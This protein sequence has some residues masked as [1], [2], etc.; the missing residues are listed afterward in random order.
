MVRIRS[1]A[2]V[3]YM[4]MKDT[5]DAHGKKYHKPRTKCEPGTRVVLAILPSLHFPS[6]VDGRMFLIW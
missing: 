6:R 3:N 1:N 5:L 4:C 2:P